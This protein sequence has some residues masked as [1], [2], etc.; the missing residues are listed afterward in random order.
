MTDPWD[1]NMYLAISLRLNAI[2]PPNVGKSC[3][4][5]DPTGIWS[6]PL[7]VN[8]EHDHGGLEDHFPVL[9]G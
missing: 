1:D 9:N 6:T 4:P 3:S 5:M 2:F 7:K 8:M